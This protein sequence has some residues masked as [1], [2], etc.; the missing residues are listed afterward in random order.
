MRFVLP[1]PAQFVICAEGV[2]ALDSPPPA[3]APAPKSL[4][5]AE[6]SAAVAALDAIWKL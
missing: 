1:F 5:K 6:Y 2:F 3:P 4:T